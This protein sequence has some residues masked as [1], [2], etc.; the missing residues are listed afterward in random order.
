MNL[1]SQIKQEQ[2]VD[3]FRKKQE[4]ISKLSSIQSVKNRIQ[5]QK[6]SITRDFLEKKDLIMKKL[7]ELKSQNRNIEEIYKYTSE[8][9]F[10][11]EDEEEDDEYLIKSS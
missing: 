1:L 4:K 5:S 7:M 2:K 6:Q 11:E 10:E 8:I 9:I 3:S